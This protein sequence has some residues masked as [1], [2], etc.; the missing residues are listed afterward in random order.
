[1]S[2]VPVEAEGQGKVDM[3]G[4]KERRGAAYICNLAVVDGQRGRGIGSKLM[5]ACEQAA[6][7]KGCSEIFLETVRQPFTASIP[8]Q[9]RQLLL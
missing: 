8:L 9:H 5:D 3:F 2:Q 1:M 7:D 4:R 6:I